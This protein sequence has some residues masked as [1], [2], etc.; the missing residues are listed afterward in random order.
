MRCRKRRRWVIG[1]HSTQDTLDDAP[2]RLALLSACG[3]VQT[4]HR[5]ARTRRNDAGR[6]LAAGMRAAWDGATRMW[7]GEAGIRVARPELLPGALVDESLVQCPNAAIWATLMV[8]L[9]RWL[10]LTLN[11]HPSW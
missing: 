1:V 8:L 10:V 4:I 5:P 7:H 2:P 9:Y 6:P 11:S 3:E